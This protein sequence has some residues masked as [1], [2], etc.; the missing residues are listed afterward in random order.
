MKTMIENNYNELIAQYI[1]S[2]DQYYKN[3]STNLTILKEMVHN[4][5]ENYCNNAHDVDQFCLQLFPEPKKKLLEYFIYYKEILHIHENFA[6]NNSSRFAGHARDHDIYIDGVL[7]H[8]VKRF[9]I[10]QIMKKY[11]TTEPEKN[12]N[13]FVNLLGQHRI[14]DKHIHKTQDY[15][16]F[17]YLSNNL[18]S[19]TKNAIN[20]KKIL[21]KPNLKTLILKLIYDVD[22]QH[23][24]SLK[25]YFK[26]HQQSGGKKVA[27]KKSK[28]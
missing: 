24:E 25:K 8:Y 10:I 6:F 22:K 21:E 19:L 13:F 28:K 4:I 23:E 20:D 1:M 7:N 17:N 15:D 14:N 26:I 3:I 11:M 27:T 16:N 2:E 12:Q 18:R 9:A 5:S